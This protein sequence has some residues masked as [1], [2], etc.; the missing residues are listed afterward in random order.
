[1]RYAD[2][3]SEQVFV[4]EDGGEGDEEQEDGGEVGGQ[5]L[6]GNLPLQLQGHE[7]HVGILILCQGQV[8]D[9]EHGQVQVLQ[10]ELPKAFPAFLL[11]HHCHLSCM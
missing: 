8:C 2:G 4:K 9:C 1:M 7:H 6:C 11:V 5:Q 3:I 10:F